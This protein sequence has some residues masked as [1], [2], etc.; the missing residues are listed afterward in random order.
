MILLGLGSNLG[1]RQANL[2]A[3]LAALGHGADAPVKLLRV[4]SVY[5]SAAL[6]PEDAPEDW[7]IPYYNI[8]VAAESRMTPEELLEAVKAVERA[9]GRQ[10]AGRWGPRVIDIDILAYG[11]RILR[12]ERLT[13]PH[14][15]MLE[16]DFVMMPLAEIQPHWHY[17]QPEGGESFSMCEAV[18]RKGMT[19]GEGILRTSVMLRWPVE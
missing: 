11:D 15:A 2:E 7:D 12:S 16:R 4:S 9:L 18:Q 6:L 5:E 3:A 19:L 10:D 8:A 13:L 17:P 1:D 14:P